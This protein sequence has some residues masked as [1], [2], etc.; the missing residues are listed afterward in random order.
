[1]IVIS[2]DENFLES[3]VIVISIFTICVKREK[4]KWQFSPF[5]YCDLEQK[6]VNFSL[7][8]RKISKSYKSVSG[9]Q[10]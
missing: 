3:S 7:I 6:L 5:T 4:Q 2:H 8:L 10:F 1:M 9:K